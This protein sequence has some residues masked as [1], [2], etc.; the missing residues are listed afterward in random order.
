MPC[1][2]SSWNKASALLRPRGAAVSMGPPVLAGSECREPGLRAA[3][4]EGMNVVRALISVDGLE[5]EQMTDHVIF[6]DDAVAA[7]HIARHAR[8]VERLAGRVAF[9]NRDHFG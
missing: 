7:M 6:V 2:A 9:E 3:E 8:D 1:C 5:I 4:N